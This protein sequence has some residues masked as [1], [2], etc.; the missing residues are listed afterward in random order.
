MSLPRPRSVLDATPLRAAFATCVVSTGAPKRAAE[1]MEL[2]SGGDEGCD[3]TECS[4]AEFDDWLGKQKPN[5]YAAD[6]VFEHKRFNNEMM[7]AW[8]TLTTAA[9]AALVEFASNTYMQ[10]RPA[11]PEPAMPRFA[12]LGPEPDFEAEQAAYAAHQGSIMSHRE[13]AIMLLQRARAVQ[14]KIS[15]V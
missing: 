7:Q 8:M 9:T 5:L 2:S 12:V 4:D 1:D 13:K 10:S 3:I 14:T 6:P 15:L 11:M